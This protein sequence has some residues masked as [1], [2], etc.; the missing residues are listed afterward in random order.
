MELMSTYGGGVG[1]PSSGA[2]WF[3]IALSL[4]DDFGWL[5]M[6]VQ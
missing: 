5:I 2:T 4:S 3:W 6:L 1:N